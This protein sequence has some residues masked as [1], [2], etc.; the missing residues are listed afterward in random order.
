[1]VWAVVDINFNWYTWHKHFKP[2]MVTGTTMPRCIMAWMALIANNSCVLYR[3]HAHFI[4]VII[5]INYYKMVIMNF[6]VKSRYLAKISDISQMTNLLL[7]EDIA[8]R[9]DLPLNR[10]LFYPNSSTY[11]SHYLKQCLEMFVDKSRY[12]LRFYHITTKTIDA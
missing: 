10:F 4:S 3:W 2:F 7:S 1:M 11:T 8:L 5:L 9:V 6:I 12:A